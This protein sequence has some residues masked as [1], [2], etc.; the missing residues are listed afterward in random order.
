MKGPNGKERVEMT[1][2]IET[3]EAVAKEGGD[4]NDVAKR[5]GIKNTSA[6]ARASKYR[7]MGFP[8]SNFTRGG[9]AKIDRSAML[10]LLASLK[11][12]TVETLVAEG[13]VL[14]AEAKQRKAEK[15]AAEAE[16][17]EAETEAKS[18]L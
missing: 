2:F 12:Q 6:L 15:E 4:S 1:A 5:L 13:D 14:V 17:T 10:A 16:A 18:A 9:G 3:W 11:G 7:S 8:L